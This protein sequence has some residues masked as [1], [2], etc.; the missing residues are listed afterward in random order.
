MSTTVSGSLKSLATSAVT[1]SSNAVVRFI[2]RGTRGA[3]PTVVGTGA[4]APLQSVN[5]I[6]FTDIAADASGNLSGTIYSTRD[7][8]G[9]GNGDITVSGS[10]TA[11]WYGMIVINNGVPGPEVPVHAKS[12]ATLDPSNVTAISTPAVSVAP[13]GDTT[14]LRLDG[15]NSPITGS[16]TTRNLTG[17]NN[18]VLSGYTLTGASSG[19]SVTLLNSQ[20]AGAAIAGTGA[21]STLFTYTIPANTIGQGKGLR[22]KILWTHSAGSAN[23]TYKLKLGATIIDTIG[24]IADITAGSQACYEIFNN[25]GVQN[26]QTWMR[27]STVG[28]SPITIGVSG[29]TSSENLANSDTLTFTFSVANTDQV[30]PKMWI[31]EV[32]Q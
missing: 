9:T 13:T 15:G 16:V 27:N 26:A 18:A 23:A 2:L 3:Q 5:G 19:N 12:G 25:A 21:D 30:T 7:A 1:S 22:L 17:S 24:P 4:I 20:G 14:Y 6:F 8:A 11:V 29:G 32:I 31:V 10:A 28:S